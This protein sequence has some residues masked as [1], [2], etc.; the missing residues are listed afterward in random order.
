MTHSK[1]LLEL[2]ASHNTLFRL[3]ADNP[4]TPEFVGAYRMSEK[5]T[6]AAIDECEVLRETWSFV[7]LLVF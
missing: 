6:R 1:T 7:E 3:A 5:K 2:F 4:D